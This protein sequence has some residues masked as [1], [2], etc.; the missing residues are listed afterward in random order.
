MKT[1]IH[2]IYGKEGLLAMLKLPTADDLIEQNQDYVA[3]SASAAVKEREYDTDEAR[4]EAFL[5][6]EQEIQATIYRAWQKSIEE[7][8]DTIAQD[9]GI[10]FV[11]NWKKDS[12]KV[13]ADDWSEVARKLMRVLGVGPFYD[14]GTFRDGLDAGDVNTPRQY[15]LKFWPEI[16]YYLEH[17]VTRD[18]RRVY[19]KALEGYLRNL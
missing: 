17:H 14:G 13:D 18:F 11:M 6:Y 10:N 8:L 19:K 15:V 16:N 4:E 3:D 5:K 12:F 1:P 9:T 7:A 2:T